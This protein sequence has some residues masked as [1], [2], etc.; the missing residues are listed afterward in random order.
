MSDS[1]L[2]QQFVFSRDINTLS[3]YIAAVPPCPPSPLLPSPSPPPSLPTLFSGKYTVYFSALSLRSGLSER[4]NAEL[5]L[6]L[7]PRPNRK[8]CFHSCARFQIV[9]EPG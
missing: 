2:L 5:D 9:P 6:A 3:L 8:R 4:L 1:S 7:S